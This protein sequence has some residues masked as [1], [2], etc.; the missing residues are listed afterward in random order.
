MGRIQ[1]I[2]QCS[3]QQ[4]NDKLPAFKEHYTASHV[5]KENMTTLEL[6]SRSLKLE[7]RNALM[8]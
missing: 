3:C 8:R 1:R 7:T 6:V 5:T 2:R 4:L